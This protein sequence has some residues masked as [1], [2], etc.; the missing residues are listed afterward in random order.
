MLVR[1]YIKQ[2]SDLCIEVRVI[3]LASLNLIV[4]NIMF[5]FIR[6]TAIIKHLKRG[7]WAIKLNDKSAAGN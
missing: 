2:Q 4:R 1:I 5:G 3:Y 7:E 6:V